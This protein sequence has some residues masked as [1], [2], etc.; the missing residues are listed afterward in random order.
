MK[1]AIV[2]GY[3]FGPILFEDNYFIQI[4]SLDFSSTAILKFVEVD[5]HE[6][7][8]ADFHLAW[9]SVVN[10]GGWLDVAEIILGK[11]IDLVKKHE[12]NKHMDQ[13]DWIAFDKHPDV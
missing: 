3:T 10:D 6:K 2:N 1:P 13:N 5:G 12:E 4:F 7:L 11:A 8:N 9:N